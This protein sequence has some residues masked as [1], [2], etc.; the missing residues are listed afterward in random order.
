MPIGASGEL[1]AWSVPVAPPTA[2]QKDSVS[3]PRAAEEHQD[4]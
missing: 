1:T 2:G 3:K 4:N